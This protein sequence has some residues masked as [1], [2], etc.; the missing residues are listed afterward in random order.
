V[1]EDT[2]TCGAY[3]AA[4]QVIAA[5]V[6][7]LP[8]ESASTKGIVLKSGDGPPREPRGYEVLAEIA[9]GLTGITALDRYSF[10]TPP[11]ARPGEHYATLHWSFSPLQ[12]A[13]FE[14]VKKL[15]A[16]IDPTDEYDVLYQAWQQ[17]WFLINSSAVWQ[18]IE[19]FATLLQ[20]S[21]LDRQQIDY[22]RPEIF[23]GLEGFEA[24]AEKVAY[25]R[26]NRNLN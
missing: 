8:I 2:D 10:G 26:P 14:E 4:G 13:D 5:L 12:L 22:L 9:I 11:S 18:A 19:F 25:H 24:G 17:A 16:L 7:G 21:S 6:E 15:V 20:G 23:A 1:T 3:R